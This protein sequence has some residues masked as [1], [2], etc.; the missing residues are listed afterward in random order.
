MAFG[1]AVRQLLDHPDEADQ[2]GRAAQAHIRE[3]FVGD[4][5]LLR[6]ARLFSSMIHGS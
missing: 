3:H 2:M 4:L 6:Y 1:S 5:H